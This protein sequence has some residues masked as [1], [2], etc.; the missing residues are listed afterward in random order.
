MFL[1]TLGT[2]IE[3]VSR[4]K[5]TARGTSRSVPLNA[6]QQ[7]R[8]RLPVKQRCSRVDELRIAIGTLDRNAYKARCQKKSVRLD[9]AVGGVLFRQRNECELRDAGAISEGCCC[10]V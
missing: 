10:E 6:S 5:E 7:R 4:I 8:P 3:R 1:P 2:E 9:A